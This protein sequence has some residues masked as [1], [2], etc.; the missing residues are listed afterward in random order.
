M[1]FLPCQHLCVCEGAPASACSCLFERH[2]P[3][4][5][6]AVVSTCEQVHG[7]NPYILIPSIIW[8]K[9][10]DRTNCST[11]PKRALARVGLELKLI[12]VL[13]LVSAQHGYVSSGDKGHLL[14]MFA[15]FR[16]AP[17]CSSSRSM[18]HGQDATAAADKAHSYGYNVAKVIE[19]D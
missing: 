16:P 19:H 11:V 7:L 4:I 9:I 6:S 8:A 14:L 5:T 12:Q 17:T 18:M 15:S 1:L 13:T 3:Q 2:L 10:I